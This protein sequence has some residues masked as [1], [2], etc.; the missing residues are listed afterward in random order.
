M[1]KRTI[2]E[3]TEEFDEQGNLRYKSIVET[4]EYEEDTLPPLF[5]NTFS[6]ITTAH[7]CGGDQ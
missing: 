2:V 4:T 7:N 6:E 5:N 3:K 1:V